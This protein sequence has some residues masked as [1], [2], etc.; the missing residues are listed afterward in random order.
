MLII[1]RS[2]IIFFKYITQFI[3]YLYMNFE[4]TNF[5]DEEINHIKLT[6]KKRRTKQTIF[7]KSKIILF[8]SFIILF[9]IVQMSIMIYRKHSQIV[10]FTKQNG[11]SILEIQA[12]KNENDRMISEIKKLNEEI[13]TLKRYNIAI[14]HDYQTIKD[15]NVEI[16]TELIQRYN[17]VEEYK[18]I[19][20]QTDEKRKRLER[21]NEDLDRKVEQYRKETKEKYNEVISLRNKYQELVNKAIKYY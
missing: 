7:P 13:E 1:N 16:G 5:Y 18:D 10:M 4:K 19:F 21:Q 17:F 14:K 3:Y 6:S 2:Y 11:H 8:I 12:K 20:Y 15:K 9:L